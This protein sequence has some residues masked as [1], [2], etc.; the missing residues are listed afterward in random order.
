[1]TEI[2]PLFDAVQ[3]ILSVPDVAKAIR[4]Y[5]KILGFP[6]SWTGGEPVVHGGVSWGKVGFQFSLDAHFEIGVRRD[7]H[8][9]ILRNIEALHQM[10]A[11][12]GAPIISPL[13]AK[14]WGMREYS[15]RDLNGY[16]LRFAQSAHAAKK[17]GSLPEAF[18]LERRVP[19]LDDYQRLIR[20][21]HWTPFTN[22][23]VLPTALQNALAGVTA[24]DGEKVIGCALL[25]GDGATFF[26]VKDVMVEPAYQ[27]RGV[28]TA[29]MT[30]L[31][32]LAEKMAPT[33][34]IIGL[35]TGPGL[36]SFYERFGFR[37]PEYLYGMSR[38]IRK[39]K[40]AARAKS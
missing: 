18:R 21:V 16:V 25:I 38:R 28:G 35:Y 23:A 17:R 40:R 34:S 10:H 22:F 27:N 14:P 6:D 7:T 29:I 3:P 36:S 5:E 24:F 37:G 30:E 32:A 1:M 9:V 13:E 20:A 19:E 15:V 2:E 39:P 12:R 4:W 33:K 11:E 8:F 26:Y 31:M